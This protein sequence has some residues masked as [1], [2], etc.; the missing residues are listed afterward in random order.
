M[1]K[2]TILLTLSFALLL[3]PMLSMAN[4]KAVVDTPVFEFEAVPE[5]PLVDA[6][7][8]IKNTGTDVLILEKVSP[9]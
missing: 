4:P 8:I 1:R 5:G 3:V 9:P 6:E 7:F 2:R